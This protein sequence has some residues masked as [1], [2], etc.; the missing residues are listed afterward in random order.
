MCGGDGDGTIS[1]IGWSECDDTGEAG[2]GRVRN[3]RVEDTGRDGWG[4]GHSW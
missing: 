3:C 1:G 2:V 4:K